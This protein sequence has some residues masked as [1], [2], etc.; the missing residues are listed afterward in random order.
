MQK[1]RAAVAIDHLVEK[2]EHGWS[3]Y[4]IM[5]EMYVYAVVLE[6]DGEL[7]VILAQNTFCS[8]FVL[9]QKNGV[10]YHGQDIVF[11]NVEFVGVFELIFHLVHL[12]C[13]LLV[14]VERVF[15]RFDVEDFVNRY[16][17]V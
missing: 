11:H 15:H 16:K 9:V 5:I 4:V 7:V 8:E 12:R 17:G 10:G 2:D 3:R 6:R 13:V 1:S 14:L